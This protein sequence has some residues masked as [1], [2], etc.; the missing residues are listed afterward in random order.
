MSAWRCHREKQAALRAAPHFMRSTWQGY[1][2]PT[3]ATG[4]SAKR[5][6]RL[7][8]VTLCA[9]LSA[10]ADKLAFAASDAPSVHRRSLRATRRRWRR[11]RLPA[12]GQGAYA[13]APLGTS[14][15]DLPSGA[16]FH[17]LYHIITNTQRTISHAHTIV[18]D[19]KRS[20]S[21]VRVHSTESLA[22]SRIE[23]GAS[24]VGRC[25][26]SAAKSVPQAQPGTG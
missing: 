8:T 3:A 4:V 26:T 25:R 15:C 16:G 11:S 2:P 23:N 12:T 19:L 17:W 14:L 20:P 7:R 22:C 24:S 10:D 6:A 21:V 1:S 9:S 13:P 18:L 5:C